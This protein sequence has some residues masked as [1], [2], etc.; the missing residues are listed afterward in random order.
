[1]LEEMRLKGGAIMT[2]LIAEDVSIKAEQLLVP[3]DATD[4]RADFIRPAHHWLVEVYDTEYAE[5][6]RIK[7]MQPDAM[8]ARYKNWGGFEEYREVLLL[9][10]ALSALRSKIVSR[11]R[12]DFYKKSKRNAKQN[13][14]KAGLSKA[15]STES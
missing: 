13:K 12:P 15:E 4:L 5:V 11:K 8:W 14:T 3:E 10:D 2:T 6:R 9:K 1:M 7:A